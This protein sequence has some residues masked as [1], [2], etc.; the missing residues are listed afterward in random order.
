MP[1]LELR[2][3]KGFGTKDYSLLRISVISNSS[4]A[5]ADNFFDY[6][7]QF[8][9]RWT[10]NYI[11]TAMKA[12]APGSPAS[13]SFA[14]THVEVSLPAQGAGVSGALIADPCNGQGILASACDFA[15][16]FQLSTRIP[17]L[18][19]AFVPGSRGTDFW[20][21]FGDNFYDRQG[22]IS[23]AAYS[24][25]SLE[26]KSKIFATVPGNHD[27][28]V[29]GHPD[30]ATSLDQCGNGH[31]QYYAQ[32]AMSAEHIL[33]GNSSAPFDY[34]V[35]PSTLLGWGCNK[36]AV[37]NFIWYNQIGNVGLVGQSGAH[38]FEESKPFMLEACTWLSKQP[39]LEVAILFGH[40]DHPNLGAS[41]DMAMPQWYEEMAAFPGCKELNE[42]SRLKFVMGHTHCNTP[43]P[44]GPV[45]AGF[46]VA[47]FGMEGC[48]NFGMPIVDTTEGRIRFWYFDASSDALYDGLMACIPE[49]GWRQCTHLATLWL[50][51]ALTRTNADWFV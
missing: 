20:G 40:W 15:G 26:T 21:I 51:Q 23:A 46:R 13:F 39:G 48:G 11:H 43:H 27:Y 42:T 32:D 50:D 12:I 14:G 18:L 9:Y 22:D 17:A 24:Q 16:R 10:Q 47:G 4:V 19:N 25:L 35:N 31:M 29:L 2:V 41:E 44:F 1:S 45:G 6:S 3:A 8:K 33:P 30:A 37:K 28:W 34:S 7:G 36:A 38:T 49:S 5:P